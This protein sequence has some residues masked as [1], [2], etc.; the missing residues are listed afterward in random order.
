MGLILQHTERKWVIPGDIDTNKY[1][2]PLFQELSPPSPFTILQ[3][4]VSWKNVATGAS[5]SKLQ[6]AGN[7][8]NSLDAVKIVDELSFHKVGTTAVTVTELFDLAIDASPAD[9]SVLLRVGN[10]HIE[11]GRFMKIYGESFELQIKNAGT[12]YDAGSVF[13]KAVGWTE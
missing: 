12:A 5:G 8:F 2:D 10:F 3:V 11:D 13:A 4:W 9:G 1:S 7:I 6:I